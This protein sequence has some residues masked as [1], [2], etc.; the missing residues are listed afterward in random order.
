MLPRS[1]KKWKKFQSDWGY[2]NILLCIIYCMLHITLPIHYFITVSQLDIRADKFTSTPLDRGECVSRSVDP[3]HRDG[4]QVFCIAGRFFTVWATREIEAQNCCMIHPRSHKLDL[5]LQV[6]SD[7]H[8]SPP[9]AS[10]VIFT[11]WVL[12]VPQSQV[13]LV[14]KN[15]PASAGDVRDAGSIPGSGRSPAGGHGNLLQHSCLENPMDRGAW[16]AIVHGVAKSQ[17]WLRD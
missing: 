9:K 7:F 3:Q 14:V 15:L 12:W 17:T 6:F 13:A 8:G 10:H 1:G 2:Q 11:Q 5:P 16:Q 4:T